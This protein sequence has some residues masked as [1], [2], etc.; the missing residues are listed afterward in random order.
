MHFWALQMTNFGLDEKFCHHDQ[1]LQSCAL[2]RG[3]HVLLLMQ[4]REGINTKRM[5]TFGHCL[6][7]G[8]GGLLMPKFFWPFFIV[9]KKAFFA[10]KINNSYIFFIHFRHHYHQNCHQNCHCS[11][12]DHQRNF[13]YL[14]GSVKKIY[15]VWWRLRRYITHRCFRIKKLIQ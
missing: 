13:F 14:Q 3:P 1:T 4:L 5:I 12:H 10:Q 15:Y 6:N 9:P 2:M 11:H 8:R 7:D